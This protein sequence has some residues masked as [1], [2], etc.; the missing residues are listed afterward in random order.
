MDLNEEY[1]TNALKS[2]AK[3]ASTEYKSSGL[4]A[5]APKR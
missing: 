2:D 5:Y 1:V 4:S 3:R